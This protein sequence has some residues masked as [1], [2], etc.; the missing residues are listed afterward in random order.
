MTMIRSRH[1]FVDTNVL[2]YAP[3]DATPF[4]REARVLLDKLWDDDVL[5]Y[6][7]HQVIREYIANATR[8]Q[9]YSPPIPMDIVLEQVE[10]FRKSF[11]ILPDSAVVLAH[12]IDL[13]R[14]VAVGGK[15]VHDTNI[16]ATMLANDIDTLLTHNVKDFDRYLGYLQVMPLIKKGQ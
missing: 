5:L 3:V 2:T 9:T 8:P 11:F 15:S 12:F 7:S 13:V 14:K 10:D 16:V 4:H 6:I 1:I